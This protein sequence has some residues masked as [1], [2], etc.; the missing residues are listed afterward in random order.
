MCKLVASTFRCFLFRF[1]SFSFFTCV[2]FT[3]LFSSIPFFNRQEE[4]E[5][6]EA[7][8][9][10]APPAVLPA[11]RE[12]D[13]RGRM[14]AAEPK[15]R[16]RPKKAEPPAAT[17]KRGRKDSAGDRGTQIAKPKRKVARK[18]T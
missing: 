7:A 6:E 3:F 17:Q 5:E 15:K 2:Q 1:R 12:R 16:G 14:P 13:P 9:P 18:K 8:P 4:E 10:A 11:A